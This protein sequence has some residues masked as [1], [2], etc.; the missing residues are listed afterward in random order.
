MKA[1]TQ[2]L[3]RKARRSF[4]AAEEFL[5]AAGVMLAVN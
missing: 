2:A 4:Q 1:D 5:N 3:L